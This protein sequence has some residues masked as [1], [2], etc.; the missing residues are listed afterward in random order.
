MNGSSILISVI[1]PCY[2]QAQYLNDA[3]QSV[4]DQTYTNWECIIV[5]DGSPDNT[6]EI[7]KK[8][9]EKDNRFHY[10]YKK[11]GGLSSARNSG[12]EIAKGKY[13]QFLDS[14]DCIDKMKLELSLIQLKGKD[15]YIKI[16]VSNFRM[17]VNSI[18]QT[19]IPYCVLKESF[20]NYE[21]LLYQWDEIFTIPVHCGFFE[22]TLFTS[23]RFPENLRAKEDWV[24]WV[25][26]FC[27]E[28][29]GVVFIDLPLAFYRRNLGG[30]MMTREMFPEYIKACEYFQNILT[31]EE[32][33]KFIFIQI[34]TYYKSSMAL[35]EKLRI[36]KQTN[37]FQAGLILKKIIKKMGLLKPSKYIFQK[38]LELE[39]VA[40]H[41]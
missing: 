37:T 25:S 32:F 5:N 7:A 18:E 2:N 26:L 16:V 4:L 35:K 6:E 10:L 21:S 29:F 15:Q 3:L 39:V 19:S 13:I 20:F 11:N 8:W 34:S 31:V 9:I 40:K 23:F 24:M 28:E 36:T 22:S 33:N 14:D 1:V 30:M 27:R 41:L 12:I 38:I 17:F